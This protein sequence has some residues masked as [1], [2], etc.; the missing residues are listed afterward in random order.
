MDHSKALGSTPTTA[1]RRPLLLGKRKNFLVSRGQQLKPALLATS[2]VLVLLAF[3]NFGL[4]RASLHGTARALADAPELSH[5]ILQQDRAERILIGAAS[6]MFLVGVFIVGVLETHRTAGAA[7]NIA[8][9]MNEIGRGR[10]GARVRLRVGDNLKSLEEGFNAM[11]A[12]LVNRAAR[13][14]EILHQLADDAERG[15]DGARIARQL[16]ALAAR[17]GGTQPRNG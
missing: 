4:Y 6:L 9:Q 13:D 14:N 15:A 12:A 2:T 8:R 3:I 1:R 10:S 7:L 17:N 11:A 5:L 16:R